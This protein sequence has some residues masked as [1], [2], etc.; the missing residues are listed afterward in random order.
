M[1]K[2][3]R[4]P[5]IGYQAMKRTFDIAASA[6]GLVL[7]SPIFAASVIG[8]EISDPGPVFYF[9]NRAGKD[10]KT[11]KMFK[12]RSMRV[13]KNADEKSLRPDQDRIFPFGRIMRSNKIDELPQLLNVFLGT[14]AVVGPR[15]AA[16]DQIPITRGGKNAIVAA[17]KPGLTTPAALYDYLY[18][19]MIEDEDEYMEKVAPTRLALDRYYLEKQSVGYDMYMK[20]LSAA[21]R[22]AKGEAPIAQDVECLVDIRIEAHIPESYIESSQLRLEVYRLIASVRNEVDA[23][24]VIDELIDRFGEPPKAVLGL[25]TVSQLRSA[26]AEAGIHEI[27]QSEEKYLLYSKNLNLEVF[28]KLSE[29]LPH[30]VTIVDK[31]PPYIAVKVNP[32]K[33]AADNMEEILSA[34]Q[35]K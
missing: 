4:K 26:A 16:V 21:V 1:K 18:G 3:V 32:S 35:S 15:P 31:T 22:S 25:I 11:F 17:I 10:N 20:M 5:G 9:A 7:T 29:K 8:I 6:A 12:F 27:R 2:R 19:D 30:R 34:L 14:M 23:M 13:D 24:D 33:S 28:A